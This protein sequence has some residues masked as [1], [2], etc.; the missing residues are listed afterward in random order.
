MNELRLASDRR[1]RYRRYRLAPKQTICQTGY[2][3]S[4]AEAVIIAAI[5]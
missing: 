1:E 4:A 5:G 3:S 2:P